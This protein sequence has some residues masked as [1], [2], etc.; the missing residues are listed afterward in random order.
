MTN[1]EKI[2]NMTIEE[3]RQYEWTVN[4]SGGK[5]STATIL[6][7]H[8]NGVPIKEIVYYRMMFNEELTATLP[9]MTNFVDNGK[10]FWETLGYKVTILYSKPATEKSNKVYFKAKDSD[11][12]GNMYG[13][14]RFARGHCKFEDEKERLG[15]LVSN[16]GM[17]MIGYRAD[18]TE[19]HKKLGGKKQSIMVALGI[20]EKDTF[21]ICRKYNMLSPLYDLGFKR[22]GCWFCPNCAKK[23]RKYLKENHPELVKMI[24]DL[25]EYSYTHYNIDPFIKSG[26]NNWLTEFIKDKGG[27][28]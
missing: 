4:W 14:T 15:K 26:R 17:Q 7:M 19:R 22:D 11:K 16:D 8:E 24:Y 6:L 18:E 1:F 9:V 27:E 3:M 10:K 2:K 20:T 13:I 28:I 21:D 25:C 23:E 12:N 5:D